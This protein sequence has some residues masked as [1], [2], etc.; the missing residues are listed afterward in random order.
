MPMAPD[1]A[2]AV[3]VPAATLRISS[4]SMSR[5]RVK[6]AGMARDGRSGDRSVVGGQARTGGPISCASMGV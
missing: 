3:P 4:V 2:M 5:P 1:R 6:Q